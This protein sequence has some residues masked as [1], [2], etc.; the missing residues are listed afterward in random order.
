MQNTRLV[1]TIIITL[2]VAGSVCL[3]VLY[4]INYQELSLAQQQLKNQQTNGKILLFANLFVDKV[5]LGQGTVS[6]DDRLDLENA[7]RDINDKEI[8]SQWQKFT[9]SRTDQES[10]T[11]V[12]NLL[13]LLFKKI[14]Q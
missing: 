6:F 1:L 2:S 7:V 9:A 5:L 10:Q 8:F 4:Y 14:Y 12:G 13:K 3:G 11:A